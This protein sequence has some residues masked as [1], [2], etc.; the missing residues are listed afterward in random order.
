M[1]IGA[2]YPMTAKDELIEAR[3][4]ISTVKELLDHAIDNLNAVELMGSE[5]RALNKYEEYCEG[6]RDAL[7]L[8]AIQFSIALEADLKQVKREDLGFEDNPD[9]C[10]FYYLEGEKDRAIEAAIKKAEFDAKFAA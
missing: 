10:W 5:A 3:A 9:S 7:Q 2:T 4:T 8:V 6:Y 1:F